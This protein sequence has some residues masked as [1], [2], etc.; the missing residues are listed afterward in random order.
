MGFIHDYLSDAFAYV[1]DGIVINDIWDVSSG[2]LH[3]RIRCD[4]MFSVLVS[5]FVSEVATSCS[6]RNAS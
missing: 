1:C 6:E 2:M 4:R 3:V 5:M